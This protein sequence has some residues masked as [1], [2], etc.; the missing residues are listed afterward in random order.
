VSQV[1]TVTFSALSAVILLETESLPLASVA[2]G[3]GMLARPNVVFLW[4]FLL[5]LYASL[6]SFTRS[7][8]LRASLR[9]ALLSL[10]PIGAAALGLMGY[11]FIRFGNP[12][13]FGYRIM[14]VGAYLKADL[15]AY[16]QFNLHFLAR[17]FE[18]MFL[19]LPRWDAA[20]G[21]LVPSALGMSI[22]LTTPAL[23]LLV[24]ARPASTWSWSA[25]ISALLLLTPLLLYFN[26]GS[27]QFGYRFLMDLIVPLLALFALA[28]GERVST[29]AKL[30][31]WLGVLVNYLGLLWF[32]AG[33]CQ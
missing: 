9:P 27:A 30:L 4:P 13:E 23:V 14:N 2:L 32:H 6:K 26:T 1:L 20:C 8:F 7:E 3:I 17:N 31:I 33:V 10:I 18:T 25:W 28:L 29:S 15:D 21:F 5:G 16:G 22:F 24:R 11:N 19:S 12:F